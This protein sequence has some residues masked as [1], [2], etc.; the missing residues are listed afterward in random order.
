MNIMF[1]LLVPFIV[2]QDMFQ[3]NWPSSGVQAVLR[4][5]ALLVSFAIASDYFYV[6]IVL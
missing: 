5:S 3:P 4:E 6:R 2:N 1:P